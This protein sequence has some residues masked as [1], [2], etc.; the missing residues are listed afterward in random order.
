[1]NRSQQFDVLARVTGSV[2]VVIGYFVVLHVSPVVGAIMMTAGDLLAIPFFIR[3][4]SWDV[5]A[6]VSFMTAVTISKVFE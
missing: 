4:K 3:T 2:T 5:V 6:M 1:M